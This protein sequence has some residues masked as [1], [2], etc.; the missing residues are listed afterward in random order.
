L[1]LEHTA[2]TALNL[3]MQ[4]RVQ[5]YVFIRAIVRNDSDAEDVLQEVAAILV[6]QGERLDTLDDFRTWSRKVARN[7]ALYFL[8]RARSRKLVSIPAEEMI[9]LVSHVVL[10]EGGSA[11]Q[12]EEM[13]ALRHCLE[14]LP[15]KSR[16]LVEMRFLG[17]R[18][19]EEI[20]TLLSSTEGAVRR[21]VARARLALLACVRRRLGMPRG[22]EANG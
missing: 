18:P 10:S 6:K 21:A 22:G 17:D 12:P 11:R 9:D 5:L 19:Y 13:A 16:Q 14:R 3:L 15:E 8:R 1:Q 2:G 4:E 20:A 7:Q